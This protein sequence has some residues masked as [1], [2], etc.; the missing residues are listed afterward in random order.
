MHFRLDPDI[1]MLR[2]RAV[3]GPAEGV[4]DGGTHLPV[5]EVGVDGNDHQEDEQS[6]P[7]L[8]LQNPGE[9]HLE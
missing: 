7:G 9:L 6:H 8:V 2:V 3:V 4:E 5:H 1:G